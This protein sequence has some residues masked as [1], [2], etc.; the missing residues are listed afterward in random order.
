MNLPIEKRTP[1]TEVER[2]LGELNEQLRLVFAPDT[3]GGEGAT[4]FFRVIGEEANISRAMT[5]IIEGVRGL[6][7]LKGRTEYFLHVLSA[8]A[9]CVCATRLPLSLA[10]AAVVDAQRDAGAATAI[11]VAGFEQKHTSKVAA[12]HAKDM[13]TAVNDR[14]RDFLFS[15]ASTSRLKTPSSVATH[16]AKMFDPRTGSRTLEEFGATLKLSRLITTFQDFLRE[17]MERLGVRSKGEVVSQAENKLRF[18]RWKKLYA[19]QASGSTPGE[20]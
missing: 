3:F 4:Y 7:E 5:K 15:F 8:C 1:H 12:H 11:F 19:S 18:A 2:L 6:P 16:V 14:I 9:H 20:I 13:Q 10:W 17:D